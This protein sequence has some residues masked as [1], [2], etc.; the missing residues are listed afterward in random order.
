MGEQGEL[1]TQINTD[2]AGYMTA[3][4]D[5]CRAENIGGEDKSEKSFTT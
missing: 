5:T 2:Y 3:G 1:L 4:N